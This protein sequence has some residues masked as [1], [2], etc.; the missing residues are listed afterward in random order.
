[1]STAVE[2]VTLGVLLASMGGAIALERGRR[3]SAAAY[4]IAGWMSAGIGGILVLVADELPRVAPLNHLLGSLFPFLLL[5][6]SI[7][8]GDRR[9]PRWLLPAGLAIGLVRTLLAGAGLAPAA[10]AIAL[11]LEIPAVAAAGVLAQRALPRGVAGPGERLVGPA[12]VLL[13]VAGAL[14]ISWLMTGRDPATWLPVLWMIV[15]PVT[16]GVQI[17]ATSEQARRA[18]RRARDRLEERVRERTDELA[19]ANVALHAEINE[20]RAAEALREQFARRVR[21]AERLEALGR[22]SGGV[23]HDFNNLLGVIL[24]N[25]RLCQSELPADTPAA[26]RLARI[27]AAAEHAAKLTDQMLLYAGKG[28]HDRKVV[29]VSRLVDDMEELLHASVSDGCS[30]EFEL[31]PRMWVEADDTQLRQVVMNLVSNANE[32][33]ADGRGRVRVTSFRRQL[34]A[35]ELDDAHAPPGAAPGA[36]VCLEVTDTGRGMDAETRARIFEPFFTTK[37]SGRGLGLATVLG[38][39]R[40][41]GG[42]VTL[43]TTPGRGTAVRVLVPAARNAVAPCAESGVSPHRHALPDRGC[44]LVVDDDEAVLEVARA[45]LE[46]A[47]FRVL[48]ACGGR[49][50]V[51]LFAACAGDID[52]VLLDVAM[53][54]VDGE[55]VFREIR[56]IRPGIPVALASGYGHELASERFAAPGVA[57]FVSKP[58][59]PEGLVDALGAAIAGSE[60]AADRHAP[61]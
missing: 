19:R 28:S 46:R 23:A 18:L 15:T 43:D 13:A 8:L 50:G 36:Y 42:I 11:V 25:T 61:V 38:I 29:D 32:A 10:Y 51:R 53:P 1:M 49:E 34:T 45:F 3:I 30:L 41:H 22:V 21:E 27:R 59:E 7:A 31:A 44:V 26:P 5:A 12:L 55:Q 35:A 33:L 2:L 58:Y 48:T 4:W 9:V 37:F 14:H 57:A 39:A 17:H 60:P 24:G 16:V 6:G 47:G 40:G 20:R 52:A 56:R 54:D